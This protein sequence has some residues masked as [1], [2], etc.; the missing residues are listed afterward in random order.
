MIFWLSFI[1]V[2]ALINWSQT[3]LWIHYQF[4]ISLYPLKSQ[5][6]LWRNWK[7]NPS[8]DRIFLFF[9]ET[10]WLNRKQLLANGSREKEGGLCES[11]EKVNHRQEAASSVPSQLLYQV[12]ID[13]IAVFR[14]QLHTNHHTTAV[15]VTTGHSSECWWLHDWTLNIFFCP[16]DFDDMR[17][18]NDRCHVT[19]GVMRSSGEWAVTRPRHHEEWGHKLRRRGSEPCRWHHTS[20]MFGTE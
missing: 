5:S 19:E 20:L 15:T 18:M 7:E 8:F 14:F 17:L 12:N 16:H 1:H 3:S 2:L 9:R 4:W 13:T 6:H 11:G 10:P